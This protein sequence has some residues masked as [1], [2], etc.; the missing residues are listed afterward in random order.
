[1]AGTI[2]ATPVE[3]RSRGVTRTSISIT[4]ATGG[5]AD[6]TNVGVGFG[7]L[8]GVMSAGPGAPLITLTDTRTGATILTHRPN[9][10]VFGNTTTGD[11]SGGTSED[12]WT[13]G[14]AHGLSEGDEIVFTSITGG[15]GGAA[16]NTPYWVVTTTGFGATT[17][18]LS[19]TA[20]HAAAGTN[21]VNVGTSDVSAATWY[22]AGATVTP[23]FFRPTAVIKTNAGAAITAADTAPNV[24]RDIYLGGKVSVEATGGE[25]TAAACTL[26]LIV[27]E[28]GVGDL[29]LTV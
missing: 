25:N 20:A 28:T 4:T 18:C 3:H 21:I 26:V 7:R 6:A 15:G 27:D 5:T 23:S 10:A 11:T 22:A 12:L 29:A 16:I 2:A 8:V 19:D 14:A 24:N 17:F 13:T 1:M 9:V